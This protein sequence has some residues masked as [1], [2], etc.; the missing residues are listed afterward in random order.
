MFADAALSLLRRRPLAPR[1]SVKVPMA[2]GPVRTLIA[3]VRSW[4]DERD[5][6]DLMRAS[7]PEIG[8]AACRNRRSTAG[9]AITQ[10]R[11]DRRAFKGRVCSMDLPLRNLSALDAAFNE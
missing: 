6:S 1:S 8:G 11:D 10:E 3:A 7:S 2:A 9:P 5:P 4:A